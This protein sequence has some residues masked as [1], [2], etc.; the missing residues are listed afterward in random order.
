MTKA[1]LADAL[2]LWSKLTPRR[3]FNAIQVFVGYYY[4]RIT[5]SPK[6]WG[7]PISLS[8]EPTTT[9]NLGCP[10]CPSGLRSFTR[11]TGNLETGMFQ[12][13]LDELGD[14]LTYCTFYFQGEPYLNPK[15]L[16]LVKL[17]SDRGIYTNTSTNAHFLRD[18]VARKTVESG[19]DRI[20]ISID[21]STQDVYEQYRVN[22]KLDKVIEGTKNLVRWKKELKSKTPYIIFQF[23]AVRPNEHQVEEVRQL[24]KDLGVDETKI[25]TAQLYDYEDGN[26]LM[27]TQEKYSRY[28]KGKDGKY[29]I[30]NPL[31]NHCWRMWQG[32]VITWDGRIV[33][34]C[35]D[36]DAKHQLGNLSNQSFYDIW[37][38]DPYLDFRRNLLTSRKSID[39]CT[40]CT[41]GTKVWS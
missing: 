35:F 25:K 14:R 39:I 11:P 2:N 18:S 16:D 12:K 1:Q 32:C 30:K 38:S 19:L 27:P 5:R 8:I 21:G 23:L 22:G 37:T 15:F 29:Q 7:A 6:P 40:N 10:E 33:P 41:E 20:I 34:C 9:C 17:A 28:K 3:L 4:S 26:P 31:L 13:V 24:G 36:K